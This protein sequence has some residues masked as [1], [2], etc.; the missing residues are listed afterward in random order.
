[1][2]ENEEEKGRD[3]QGNKKRDRE[4][5]KDR[6]MLI[7]HSIVTPHRISLQTDSTS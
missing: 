6:K 3:R 1:M 5:E 2:T 7:T 4:R